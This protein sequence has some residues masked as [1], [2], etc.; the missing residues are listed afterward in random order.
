MEEKK[1]KS[2]YPLKFD[3]IVFEKTRKKTE[4][5]KKKNALENISPII[6]IFIQKSNQIKV[7]KNEKTNRFGASE[8]IWPKFTE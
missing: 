7:E 2:I 6:L 4:K 3:L 8:F 1:L 5:K